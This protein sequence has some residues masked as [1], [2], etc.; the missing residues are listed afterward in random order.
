MGA[1]ILEAMPG[2]VKGQTKGN[3][4]VTQEMPSEPY[5]EFSFLPLKARC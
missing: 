3:C 2:V 4:A 1:L 5:V